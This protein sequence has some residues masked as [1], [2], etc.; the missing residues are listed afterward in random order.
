M[1]RD[2]K[3]YR[4]A[5]LLASFIIAASLLLGYHKLLRPDDF[6]L[7]V[8]RFHVLPDAW[9]NLV[10]LYIPWLEAVCA[11]CLLFVPRLRTAALWIA[12]GLLILFTG[13][14]VFNL[15]RG[16][17]FGCGCFGSSSTEQPV[18][19]INVA[20]NLA[21]IALVLLAFFGKRKSAA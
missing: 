13:G 15:M 7:S 18:N 21:L 10:A 17:A 20:R 12:L 2:Q 19:W 8:Y 3:I 5:Y 11:I 4:F 6:A 16:S 9:V 1:T 14:I